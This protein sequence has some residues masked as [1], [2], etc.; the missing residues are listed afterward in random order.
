MPEDIEHGENE[1]TDYAV[2]TNFTTKCQACKGEIEY[3]GGVQ[4]P[5]TCPE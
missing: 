4:Q 2:A 3:V 1:A 5:H